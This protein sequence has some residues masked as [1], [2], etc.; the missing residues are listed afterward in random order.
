MAEGRGRGRGRREGWRRDE[1]E[2]EGEGKGRV[3]EGR[4]RGRERA[5]PT[6]SSKAWDREGVAPRTAQRAL[7]AQ[8]HLHI[9]QLRLLPN[10]VVCHHTRVRRQLRRELCLLQPLRAVG[11]AGEGC[12]VAFDGV[13]ADREGRSGG[14]GGEGVSTGRHCG[15]VR[16]GARGNE[17]Q[18]REGTSGRGARERMR[19]A[20]GNE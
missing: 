10:S 20:R 18:G 13:A 19:G 16:A 15:R 11:A 14:G 2:G 4:G 5:E 9:H 12:L 6:P 17:W 7:L 8:L 3:A 1:G